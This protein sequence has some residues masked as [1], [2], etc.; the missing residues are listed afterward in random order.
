MSLS[1]TRADLRRVDRGLP[2]GGGRVECVCQIQYRVASS[3]RRSVLCVF[4]E[5]SEVGWRAG[6]GWRFAPD[7]FSATSPF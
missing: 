3:G 5:R 1:R 6:W 2:S 7:V 4:V